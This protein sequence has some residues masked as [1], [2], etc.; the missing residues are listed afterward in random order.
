M[1]TPSRQNY[2]DLPRHSLVV[3]GSLVHNPANLGS[4]CRM[5][6]AFR[7]ESL[8]LPDQG[9]VADWAFRHLAVSTHQWQPLATCSR[10]RLV[11]WLT[12]QQQRGYC[13]I[14]LHLCPDAVPLPQFV[15]PRRSLLV[16]GQELT[17]VPESVA[18]ACDRALVIPQ[19]GLVESLNVSVAAAIAAYAYT[20]QHPLETP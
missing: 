6:E 20:Q 8:V 12:E 13:A 11:P 7:L 16:L 18:A 10:D 15:F 3:C 9:V 4:L 1:E 17:G 5:A 2:R 14:A 19:W